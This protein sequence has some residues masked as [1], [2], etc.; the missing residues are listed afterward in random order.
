MNGPPHSLSASVSRVSHL[1]DAEPT[2]P[3]TS[4]RTGPPWRCGTGWPFISSASIVCGSIAFGW[5]GSG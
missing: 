1:I 3:G 4:K 2:Q 5:D